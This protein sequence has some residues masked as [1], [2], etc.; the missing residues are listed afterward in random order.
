VNGPLLAVTGPGLFSAVPGLFRRVCSNIP[1][2][3]PFRRGRL[4]REALLLSSNIAGP[5]DDF[6]PC[7][8]LHPRA[9][10][11]PVKVAGWGAG[12]RYLGHTSLL[13]RSGR[14]FRPGLACSR[15]KGTSMDSTE[16]RSTT[17]QQLAEFITVRCACAPLP[18]AN[19]L[20]TDRETRSGFAPGHRLSVPGARRQP[21][22]VLRRDR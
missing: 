8:S 1:P 13:V 16:H 17:F 14:S 12:V 18:A 19:A 22:R 2:D 15:R 4:D 7:P 11:L 20:D 21:D 5:G 3:A 10:T 9:G 6:F